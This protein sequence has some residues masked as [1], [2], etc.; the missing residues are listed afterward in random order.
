MYSALKEIPI[1]GTVL[2]TIELLYGLLSEL[3]ETLGIL[4]DAQKKVETD[5]SV[6]K[7][8]FAAIA[9]ICTAITSVTAAIGDPEPNSKTALI[10]AAI[11]SIGL[12][13]IAIIDV[14]DTIEKSSEKDKL[15]EEIT[16]LNQRKRRIEDLLDELK[17]P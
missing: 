15:Q 3:T 5:G 11:A 14:I 9:A 16:K 6:W 4:K 2:K 13:I 7:S 17:N 10:V 8:I 1:V 12:A